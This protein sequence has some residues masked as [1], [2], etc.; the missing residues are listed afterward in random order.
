MFHAFLRWV[1]LIGDL[2]ETVDPFF[3]KLV[4]KLGFELFDGTDAEQQRE[5]VPSGR[6]RQRS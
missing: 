4:G 5:K 3:I 2:D 6:S 1:A